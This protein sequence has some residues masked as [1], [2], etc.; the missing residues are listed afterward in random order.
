MGA[1]IGQSYPLGASHALVFDPLFAPWQR[2]NRRLRSIAW[3][4]VRATSAER[5]DLYRCR[6][7]RYEH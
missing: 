2:P 4:S 1:L 5:I 7:P 6:H 3:A